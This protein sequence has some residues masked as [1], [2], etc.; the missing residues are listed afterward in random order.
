M[1]ESSTVIQGLDEE[2]HNIEIS[3][4]KGG[5]SDWGTELY[6]APTQ[7][8]SSE[9]NLVPPPAATLLDFVDSPSGSV[10]EVTGSV[11]TTTGARQGQGSDWGS[12]EQQRTH[13]PGRAASFLDSKGFGWLLEVEEDEEEPKPL[14]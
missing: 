1:S 2:Y 13:P 6:I 9:P 14:L 5:G 12:L 7:G 3:E 11:D 4:V 10:G 8:I